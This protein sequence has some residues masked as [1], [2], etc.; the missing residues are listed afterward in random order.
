MGMAKFKCMDYYSNSFSSLQYNL[1]HRP[2]TPCAS[3]AFVVLFLLLLNAI[4]FVSLR[5]PFM[6][7]LQRRTSS[8]SFLAAVQQLDTRPSGA[9]GRHHE[10]QY[11]AANFLF[12]NGV[13]GV[14]HSR[15]RLPP[16]PPAGRKK[17]QKRSAARSRRVL[18]LVGQS[19]K[20]MRFASR[21]EAFFADGCKTRFF[22]T[23]ISPTEA[24]F[25]ARESLTVESIFHSHPDAC[26]LLLSHAMD[27]ARGRRLLRPFSSL[28]L[29]IAAVSPDFS[30]LFRRTPAET[31]FSRL[32]H[33]SVDPGDVPLGQNL[34]NLLR[35]AVLYKFGGVY[36]DADVIVLR[37]FASLRN[38]I[39]A[40]AADV[41]TGSW[42]RLNNA[43]MVFDQEHPLLY[44][45]ME[46]FT[47]TFNGNKW[48]HNGPYLVS[49]VVAREPPAASPET[50]FSVLP[51][52]A[53]Y[54]VDWNRISS[55]FHGPRSGEHRRWAAA[56][57]DAI[58]RESFA[59]H[60][61]NRQ[62]KGLKVEEG[63][64]M[65]RLMLD[66]CLLCNSSSWVI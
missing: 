3:P 63:S 15:P 12:P 31:W 64:V 38:T 20:S 4:A 34:S 49:R 6:P 56:K 47:S 7:H 23:W 43:V 8:L 10:N 16:P 39:G 46:E 19:P 29:R 51:P 28:G 44:K 42:S 26:V 35:L 61:W 36:V 18:E 62:S 2:T 37:S 40:Q 53:F 14:D 52:A 25:G 58:R 27:S 41:R 66:T 5:S 59:I 30:H 54:P 48:G 57:L 32:K 1:Q 60:L 45:F 9:A 17:T 33:G 50:N 22:L 55:L 13:T 11:V 24:V 65:K 21:A